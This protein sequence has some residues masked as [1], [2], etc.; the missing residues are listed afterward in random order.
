MELHMHSHRWEQRIPDWQA[1]AVS[2][3]AGGAVLM[4][5]ELFWSNMITDTSPWAT[6]HLIA[7]IL[8]GRDALQSTGF[9][10][11]V[12]A[13]ALLTHYMLGIIYGVMLAAII[14]P[15]HFDSSAGMVLLTGA[16]FGLALYLLNFYG[17]VRFFSWFAE[18]RGWQ[19]L[20]AHLI[21]GMSAAIL[22]WKLERPGSDR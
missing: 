17:L 10:I 5:L 12:V 2:G 15:F 14:A 3:F 13:L 1:A 6:S 19:T 7:A 18:I 11:G 20:M 8:M 4:V 22:Y 16:V 9:S 21:F